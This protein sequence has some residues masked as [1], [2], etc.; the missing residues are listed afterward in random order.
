MRHYRRLQHR[1]QPFRVLGRT[2]RTQV[3]TM[4]LGPTRDS[5]PYGT[6][7]PESDQILYVI[8]GNG[9]AIVAGKRTRVSSGDVIV[10]R[11]GEAHQIRNRGRG[12]LKTLNVYA[13]PAY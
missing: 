9:E 1:K 10:I 2:A 4:I 13:P 5:G 8:A 6:D 12:T 7:H 3:A 11:A